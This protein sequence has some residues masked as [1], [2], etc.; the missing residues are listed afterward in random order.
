MRGRCRIHEVEGQR[1]LR[2][3]GVTL[4]QEILAGHLQEIRK[5]MQG[6]TLHP[7]VRADSALTPSAGPQHEQ[8]DKLKQRREQL[9]KLTRKRRRHSRNLDVT[10]PL[11][12]SVQSA[13]RWASKP[14][15]SKKPAQPSSRDITHSMSNHEWD[16]IMRKLRS[17]VLAA[18]L[19]PARARSLK[20]SVL[21]ESFQRP[22]ERVQEEQE[23]KE[24]AEG[25]ERGRRL[26]RTLS[27]V[28][29]RDELSGAV[30]RKLTSYRSSVTGD[31]MRG[32]LGSRGR[33]SLSAFTPR[34]IRPRALRRQQS[35]RQ[36]IMRRLSTMQGAVVLGASAM[37]DKMLPRRSYCPPLCAVPASMLL[38]VVCPFPCCPPIPPMLRP[39]V[40]PQRA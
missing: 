12:R 37:A 28:R 33:A 11:R 16:K 34:R 14:K 17:V 21:L 3:I 10:T 26:A 36:A 27:G 29:F 20:K 5:E 32:G 38:S 35:T 39:P 4:Q 30:S 22:L 31:G 8:H 23:A 2:T 19:A 1:K 15:P 6:S 24:S 13:E 9:E 18:E 25:G 7:L 40:P